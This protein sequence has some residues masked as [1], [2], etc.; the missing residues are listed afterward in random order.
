MVKRVELDEGH[1]EPLGELLRERRLAG[2]RRALD[3]DAPSILEQLGGVRQQLSV[4][5]CG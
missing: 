3:V 1:A 2:A 4:G 5:E